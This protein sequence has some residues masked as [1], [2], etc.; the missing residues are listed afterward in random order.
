MNLAD[1]ILRA[2]PEVIRRRTW[3]DLLPPDATAELLEVKKRWQAGEYG[4]KIK[5]M[6]IGKLLVDRCHERGW[7]VCDARRMGEWLQQKD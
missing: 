4:P 1:E 7:N 5:P 3:F 2:V 6:T